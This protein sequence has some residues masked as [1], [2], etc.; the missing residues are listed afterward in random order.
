M[1]A[2]GDKAPVLSG[3][4][5]RG[6]FDPAQ[7]RLPSREVRLKHASDPSSDRSHSAVLLVGH[8]RTFTWLREKANPPGV[9]F[10]VALAETAEGRS[11]SIAGL[12]GSRSTGRQRYPRES[13]Q[14][15]HKQGEPIHAA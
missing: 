1:S 14:Q 7:G 12:L 3:L 9:N 6:E 11:E 15:K 2:F 4:S 10:S 5:P 13:E 8:G